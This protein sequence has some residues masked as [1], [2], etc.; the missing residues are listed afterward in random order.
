MFGFRGVF[1]K[2]HLIYYV[3]SLQTYLPFSINRDYSREIGGRKVCDFC[4]SKTTG[5]NIL[6]D[7]IR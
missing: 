5:L 1:M 6:A 2:G 4:L 3:I 7:K